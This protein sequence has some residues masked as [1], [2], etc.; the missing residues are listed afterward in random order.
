MVKCGFRL[1][2]DRKNYS[3]KFWLKVN[4]TELFGRSEIHAQQYLVEYSG[5]IRLGIN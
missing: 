4:N 5:I 2:I 3:N 1:Y